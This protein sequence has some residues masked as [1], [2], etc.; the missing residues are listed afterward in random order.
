MTPAEAAERCFGGETNMAGEFVT[1]SAILAA[2]RKYLKP[3]FGAELWAELESGGYPAFTEDYVKPALALYVKKLVLPVLAAQAGALGIVSYG[4]QNFAGAS[5]KSVAALAAAVKSQAD[6][7]M[8]ICI[9]HIEA[10][11]DAF[12][13][14]DPRRNVKKSVNADGGVV[15]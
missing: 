11:P 9:E 15:L 2:Q 5:D 6:T 7:L 14:Y 4:G 12:P 8:K 13:E 10:S 3:V 1:E